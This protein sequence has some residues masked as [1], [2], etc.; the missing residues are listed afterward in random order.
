MD[1]RSLAWKIP[2]FEGEKDAIE[3]FKKRDL[4]DKKG[5]EYIIKKK[6]A[7]EM[8]LEK[9]IWNQAIEYHDYMG[10]RH[11]DKTKKTLRSVLEA[12]YKAMMKEHELVAGA[13]F[14]HRAEHGHYPKTYK[15]YFF[16]VVKNIIIK[17]NGKKTINRNPT[18][19][20][21]TSGATT[22]TKHEPIVKQSHNVRL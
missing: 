9:F 1:D 16:K 7:A 6:K 10:K 22:S 2:D 12:N 17:K 4:D 19:L 20:L 11:L 14:P 8:K 15:V 3:N 5:W 18:S 21:M 13:R